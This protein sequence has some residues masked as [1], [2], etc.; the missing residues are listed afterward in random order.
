MPTSV[1]IVPEAGAMRTNLRMMHV[2]LPRWFTSGTS[3]HIG[4]AL[5]APLADSPKDRMLEGRVRI[6]GALTAALTQMM[7][8]SS[9]AERTMLGVTSTPRGPAGPTVCRPRPCL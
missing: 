2:V 8:N 6:K 9:A 1:M 4:L 7:P 3:A 5:C